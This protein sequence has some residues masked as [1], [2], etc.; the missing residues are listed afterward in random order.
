VIEPNFSTPDEGMDYLR[1]LWD[2]ATRTIPEARRPRTAHRGWP[3]GLLPETG[4]GVPIETSEGPAEQQL[5]ASGA[6]A[7]APIPHTA[8]WG[9]YQWYGPAA[10]LLAPLVT[11][12]AVFSDTQPTPPVDAQ[13]VGTDGV[14]IPLDTD[15]GPI[16]WLLLD[17]YVYYIS[18]THTPDRWTVHEAPAADADLTH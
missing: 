4:R 3:L 2:E 8:Q 9:L 18:D 10:R 5:T 15:A 17:G 13:V 11:T 6:Y 12:P 14:G 1:G 7:L 16:R